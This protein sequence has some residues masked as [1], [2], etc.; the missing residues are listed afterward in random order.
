[1]NTP[2]L[3]TAT[4][5]GSGLR[6]AMAALAAL[7]ALTLAGCGPDDPQPTPA[8]A[9][10]IVAQSNTGAPMGGVAVRAGT[11]RATTSADGRY[12]LADVPPAERPVVSFDQP[13]FARQVLTLR[14]T[15]GA[16]AR[17]DARLSPVGATQAV[18][19]TLA[20]TVTVPGSPAQVRLPANC[21]VTASGGAPAGPV[22]VRVTPIDP[23]ADPANM[24]G[25]YRAQG[26][27]GTLRA[28]ES[29][30]AL[31]VTLKD[32]AGNPLNLA[33]G[34]TAT[35]RIPVATRAP[36][37]PATIPLYYFDEAI[38]LWVQEGTATLAGTAPN[39]YYEGTVAHFTTWNADQDAQ[40]VQVRGFLNGCTAD[41]SVESFGVDYSG[42]ASST[43]G[44]NCAFDVA[45]RKGSTAT[46]FAQDGAR[47]SNPVRV[48]PSQ[49]DIQLTTPLVLSLGGVPPQIVEQP[50][51]QTAQ[52]DSFA[53][54]SVAAV[55]SP[56]L[57][58]QWQRNGVD[59]PGET[60]AYLAR[61]PVPAS[62]DGARFT[63]VVR[64]D[65]GAVTSEVAVLTVNT[66]PLPPVILAQP[67][68]V[69]VRLG[70]TAGFEVIAAT[71]GGALSYQ[72]RRNGA[73]IR[74]ADA[75]RYTTPA[76]VLAD[77]GA[78][79]SVTVA[80]SSGTSVTSAGARLTVTTVVPLAITAQPQ[81][82]TVT[83]GQSA[84]FTVGVSGGTAT[85]AY[86]WRR[87]G[88]PIAGATAASYTTPPTS[89]QADN[90]AVFSVVVTSGTETL[91]SD[92]AALT[93]TPAPTGN[94]HYLLAQDDR[95]H[96]LRRDGSDVGIRP[97]SGQQ[98]SVHACEK[99]LSVDN[100][101]GMSLHRSTVHPALP[102]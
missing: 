21:I 65:Y 41:S 33:T 71:Q 101:V 55:G 51:S 57:R 93:V 54:F 19:P 2:L 70:E 25:D 99:R 37:V 59:L 12:T 3:K 63:V 79:F 67:A 95:C 72:W 7:G 86:Q 49:V 96:A 27:G 53:L 56:V 97:I 6:R 81:P 8:P 84:G 74:G 39:R 94:G 82:A 40:T 16:T 15:A 90:G 45:I 73:D 13:G 85:P 76:T 89:V 62:D 48:G 24:P 36:S 87:N 91:T 18:D 58:Y 10:G 88:T 34:Q 32:A 29:F 28:I 22:T 43:P 80:S 1:M 78:V 52:L 77:D 31:D 35:I 42:R 60:T 100:R 23:A 46:L 30:C 69:S 98:R 17:G 102:R 83:A 11:R 92:G 47:S 75:T 5:I 9:T 4:R 68:A 64:N 20:A 38:G 44:S 14:V 50:V 66:T 26:T 61:Q